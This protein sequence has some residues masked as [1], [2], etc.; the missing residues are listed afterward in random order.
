MFKFL[1]VFH[2]LL[3]AS[4][5]SDSY[6]LFQH[7]GPINKPIPCFVIAKESGPGKQLCELQEQYLAEKEEFSQLEKYVFSNNTKLDTAPNEISFG[8]FKVQVG[9][10]VSYIIAGR[11]SAITYFTNLIT[12]LNRSNNHKLAVAIE[13]NILIRLRGI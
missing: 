9:N 6:V 10:K 8:S 13:R 2:I 3:L 11:Q 7:I 4:C 5:S 12:Q 1:F